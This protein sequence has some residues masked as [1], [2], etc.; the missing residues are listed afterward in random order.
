MRTCYWSF[1]FDIQAT[2]NTRPVLQHQGFNLQSTI[3]ILGYTENEIFSYSGNGRVFFY[4]LRRLDAFIQTNWML[5]KLAHC[6]DPGEFFSDILKINW[7]SF[8]I[9]RW[10]KLESKTLMLHVTIYNNKLVFR[11][12]FEVDPCSFY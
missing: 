6:Y 7:M 9:R 12:V 5:R 11:Y 3:K 8:V 1:T 4:W 2:E 10:I